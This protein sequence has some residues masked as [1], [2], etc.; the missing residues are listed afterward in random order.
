MSRAT[1][2]FRSLSTEG[3]Y[4]WRYSLDLK[5]RA[6]EREASATQIWVQPP[7]TP[8]VGQAFLRAFRATG[9]KQYL[10][11]AVAAARALVKGQLE[12]GGWDYVVEFDP[13]LRPQWNYRG[14]NTGAKNTSTL[15]DNN[16]QAAIRLL[17]DV[18]KAAPDRSFQ[19]AIDYALDSLLRV[20]AANGAFPQRYPA[21]P[22]GYYSYY[23]FNDNTM[24]DVVDTLIQGHEF[25]KDKRYLDAVRKTGD[26]MLLAQQPEPQPVW[27]QQYDAKMK[28]AWARKFEPPSVCSQESAG[29]I[30]VLIRVWL[31]T[32][33][34]K[35]LAP[36]P[37]A[38]AWFERSQIAPGKWARFYEIGTN[39]PLY[40]TRDYKLVYTDT[41]LPTH[42]S[43]QGEYNV[44]RTRAEYEAVR[45][46]R[47][48][49]ARA[50]RAKKPSAQQK[51]A[52]R[53]ALDPLVAGIATALDPEGRWVTNGQIVSRVFVDNL[54]T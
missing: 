24:A 8:A 10:D 6:G 54:N 46:R 9:D 42:Y 41:D 29:V 48:E 51:A 15:D 36:I 50:E 53:K 27:A 5:T 35:Y 12:S 37:A 45:G 39:K 52:R 22:D 47:V 49:D 7:G 34:A 32:G 38:L 26:F 19:S 40:F 3:G 28:P 30:R 31:A 11:A 16:T 43:F 2:F 14:T 44:P 23:T 13:K 4:L 1:K 17:M 18:N 21:P 20:Q 25:Y 33:D